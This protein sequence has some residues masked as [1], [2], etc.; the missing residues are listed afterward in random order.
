MQPPDI[1]Q[2]PDCDIEGIVMCLKDHIL[3]PVVDKCT[4]GTDPGFCRH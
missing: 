3:M 4:G 1:G 2:P